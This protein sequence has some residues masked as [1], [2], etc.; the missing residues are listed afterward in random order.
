MLAGARATI[1]TRY[2]LLVGLRDF[3]LAFRPARSSPECGATP[4]PSQLQAGRACDQAAR[5]L[6]WFPQGQGAGQ[7]P[8]SGN[9]EA[10][11]K[12]GLRSQCRP[13]PN[14]PLPPADSA[15]CARCAPRHTPPRTS[16]RL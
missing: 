4:W 2:A 11:E 7:V 6:I 14:V 16:T 12:L 9:A 1:I 5:L 13:P 10:G 8:L 3:G 15:Q